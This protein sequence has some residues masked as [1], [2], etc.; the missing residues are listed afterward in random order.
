MID[1]SILSDSNIANCILPLSKLLQ[2]SPVLVKSW[3]RLK[4]DGILEERLI[5]HMLG[6]VLDEN[7]DGNV[8]SLVDKKRAV[9]DLMCR[10]DLMCQRRPLFNQV[11]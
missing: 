4:E 5:D 9:L 3:K 1:K 6:E 7:R 8:D 10:F 2:K 11:C